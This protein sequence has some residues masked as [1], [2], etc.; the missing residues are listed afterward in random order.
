[1][2][3]IN[4][5]QS[6]QSLY[7]TYS[8]DHIKLT[9]CAKCG[10]VVDCYVEFDNILLFI[11]LLLLKR[12]AYKHLVFNSLETELSKFEKNKEDK[13][14][15][16]IA[17]RLRSWCSRNDR[18]NR[19]WIIILAFEIYL[20][21]V[22]EEQRSH[23]L[24]TSLQ[25]TSWTC[26]EDV[27]QKTSLE[28]Y[29]FFSFYCFMDLMLFRYFTERLLL[30]HLQWG[31]EYK[32]AGDIIS[33]TILLSYGAK[34]FPVLMLIW[35]YDSAAST[36]II[37]GV[38]NLYIIEALRMVTNKSYSHIFTLFVAVC[39]LKS[40]CI[41][42]LICLLVSGFNIGVSIELMKRD[43]QAASHKI[44]SLLLSQ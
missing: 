14:S 42:A 15:S 31:K 44:S 1:M 37:K 40:I 28:Q 4:C 6:T 8:S 10:E 26:M 34:I 18:L 16:S 13:G 7:V 3:C 23:F 20:T 17:Q 5:G 29:S 25:D 30:S 32:Y 21:W 24:K 27:L 43:Y 12:E 11:D 9:D 2:I 19:L 39:I 22:L 36:F 41:K 38:A 33:Y 35:P